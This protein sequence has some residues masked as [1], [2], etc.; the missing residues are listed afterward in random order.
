[1]ADIETYSPLKHTLNVSTNSTPHKRVF[2]K[3]SIGPKISQDKGYKRKRYS[4][5]V[6]VCT[7]QIFV[8]ERRKQKLS[9]ISRALSNGVEVLYANLTNYRLNVEVFSAR[10]RCY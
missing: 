2:K 9:E 4:E 3:E 10:T 8:N 5:E 7:T 6:D 1:M